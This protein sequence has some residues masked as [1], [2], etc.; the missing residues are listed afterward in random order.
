MFSLN[1]YL[2][3]A[4]SKSLRTAHKPTRL[5]QNNSG[6]AHQTTGDDRGCRN[7]CPCVR[8]GQ[9]PSNTYCGGP[10]LQ[11]CSRHAMS[12]VCGGPYTKP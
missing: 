7:Y 4:V 12:Q 10:Y 3:I 11:P 6:L 9:C 5:M 1:D 2:W 8:Q